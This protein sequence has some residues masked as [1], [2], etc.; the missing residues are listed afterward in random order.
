MIS[1]LLYYGAFYLVVR[2]VTELRLESGALNPVVFLP[3]IGITVG[4]CEGLLALVVARRIMPL[5]TGPL[6]HV[7]IATAA[8]FIAKFVPW[9][10]GGDGMPTDNGFLITACVLAAVLSASR[11]SSSLEKSRG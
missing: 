9:T 11:P 10:R 4:L 1:A 2:F 5:L 6:A 3:A 7:V 8:W